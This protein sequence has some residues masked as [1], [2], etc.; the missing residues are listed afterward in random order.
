MDHI[1]HVKNTG[2]LDNES[3]TEETVS[4]HCNKT[5]LLARSYSALFN[6]ESTVFVSALLHDLGKL[7][8]DFDGYIK[9]KNGIKRGE[10][11][12]SYAGAKFLLELVSNDD[13]KYKKEVARLIARIIISHHGLNDWYTRNNDDYFDYRCSKN[14]RYDEIKSNISELISD[15]ELDELLNK[16]ADEYRRIFEKMKEICCVK[17]RKQYF[18]TL[19][20]YHGLLERLTESCLIDA[21]RTATAE[22]MEGVEITEPSEDEIQ[23]NWLDMKQRLDNKLSKFSGSDSLISKLRMN[24]SDRCCAFAKNDVGIAQLIVPTGG[25]K[26]LSALRFAI[27]YAVEHKKERIFYISP[28]MSI[29]EQ[30]GDVIREIAGD[31]NLSITPICIAR[32][33][34]ISIRIM[35]RLP[36]SLRTMSCVAGIGINRLF[37]LLWCSSLIHY[38]R[39][40]PKL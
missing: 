16:A 3:V 13:D 27:E 29:L 8:Y 17:D 1:S 40:G 9:H 23:R 10:I 21:D 19:A 22:F 39:P 25:G 15:S 18:T 20:F 38:S 7:N 26:T 2:G 28:F 24:I 4:E 36:T 33:S 31:D 14:E 11:D 37:A 30:N 6:M 32:L 35:M 5:A 34:I 12:H